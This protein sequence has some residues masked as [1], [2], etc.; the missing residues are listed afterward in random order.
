[1]AGLGP[2]NRRAFLGAMGLSLFT[3]P[4]LFADLITT[5]RVTEGPFYPT[6]L[7]LDTDNDLII[8]NHR[9]TPAIGEITHLTGRVLD[10][11]GAPVRNAGVEIWQVDGNGA[12]LHQGSSNAG[13]RD[14]NFQGFGRFTTNANGDYYFRTVKPVAYPGRCP[15]IHFK[16]YRNGREVLCSQI[17]I[18]GE[19][20]NLRDGIFRGAGG[21]LEREVLTAEFAPLPGT[22]TGELQARFDIV[23]GRT[24]DER[25]LTPGRR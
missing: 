20:S 3:T 16:V 12:Y 23:I 14:S 7:P 10:V 8:V 15:H 19:P 1:M 17:F 11:T 4:G 24:P 22:T 9:L 2:T 21:P 5:P 25:Q 13:R 18:A 6:T